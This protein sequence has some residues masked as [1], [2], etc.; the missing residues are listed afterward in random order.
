[1]VCVLQFKFLKNVIDLITM[2]WRLFRSSLHYLGKIH[3]MMGYFLFQIAEE[4]DFVP[5]KLVEDY[6]SGCTVC[7]LKRGQHVTAPFQPILTSNYM[8]RLQV[9]N[10][11]E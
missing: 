1:M 7:T 9:I 8:E 6:C 2:K 3:V 4:Y 5:R 10:N 11:C